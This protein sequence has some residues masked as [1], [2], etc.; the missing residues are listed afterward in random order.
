MDSVIT[1]AHAEVADIKP[2]THLPITGQ[3]TG[4][5]CDVLRILR[6]PLAER[7]ERH[8]AGMTVTGNSNA[9]IK[10]AIPLGTW[11]TT[12]VDGQLNCQDVTLLI[13][14]FGLTINNI[15]GALHFN[16]Q[17]LFAQNIQARLVKEPLI[18]DIN[19]AKSTNGHDA[20]THIDIKVPI[21]QATLSTILPTWPWE[22]LEGSAPGNLRLNIDHQKDNL[23]SNQ[24]QYQLQS[25]LQGLEIN[26]PEPL[27]KTKT[28]HKSITV[29]GAIPSN[30]AH[31]I[32]LDYGEK[33]HAILR[34]GAGDSPKMIAGAITHDTDITPKLKNSSLSIVGHIKRFDVTGWLALYDH[35]ETAIHNYVKQQQSPIRTKAKLE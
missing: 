24:L 26:L 21:N 12:Q 20:K 27:G 14:E 23:Q 8:V 18:V 11:A 6:G 16:D 5:F 19:T 31:Q 34:M 13:N 30:V 35:Y 1:A 7:Y 22:L 17:G 29:T 3:A 2:A 9:K 10:I 28:S 15:N 33:L 4:P 32:K 25:N